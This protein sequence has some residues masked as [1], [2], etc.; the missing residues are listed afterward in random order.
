MAGGGGR[1]KETVWG[2]W[3]KTSWGSRRRKREKVSEKMQPSRDGYGET[4]RAE[5]PERSFHQQGSGA[6]RSQAPA[7]GEQMGNGS[8]LRPG[9]HQGRT[10]Q[11]YPS[12]GLS[13]GTQVR[14]S[15]VEF[16]TFEHN[17]DPHP[18]PLPAL[19]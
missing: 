18:A 15:A 5:E 6:G 7:D 8:V 12:P 11:A 2:R 3:G 4:P 10:G 13:R 17:S 16:Q 1:R 9:V 14:Q 19:T